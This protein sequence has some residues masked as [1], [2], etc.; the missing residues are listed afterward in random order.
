MKDGAQQFFG[1]EDGKK[2][3]VHLYFIFNNIYLYN[4]YMFKGACFLVFIEYFYYKKII[5]HCL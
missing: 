3:F 5:F 1:D 4:T 2:K